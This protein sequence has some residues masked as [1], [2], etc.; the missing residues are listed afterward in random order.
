MLYTLQAALD[1]L[2]QEARAAGRPDLVEHV[3]GVRYIIGSICHELDK[4]R[5]SQGEHTPS[6]QAGKEPGD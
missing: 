3:Q 2:H 4:V 5:H 1:K 6:P